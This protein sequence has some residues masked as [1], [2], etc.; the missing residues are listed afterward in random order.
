MADDEDA[1]VVDAGSHWEHA[2]DFGGR[3]VSA[4]TMDKAFQAGGLGNWRDS[5]PGRGMELP[6]AS[7]EVLSLD[8]W[9]PAF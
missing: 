9:G 7:W 1:Y 8:V 6:S 4:E 5:P 2:V 3:A